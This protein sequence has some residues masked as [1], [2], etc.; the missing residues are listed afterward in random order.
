MNQHCL[1]LTLKIWKVCAAS[2]SPCALSGRKGDCRMNER[3][4]TSSSRSRL[5]TFLGADW[6]S[7]LSHR[8][9]PVQNRALRG[10]WTA[11]LRRPWTPGRTWR[12]LPSHRSASP[13]RGCFS[14]SSSPPLLV[15]CLVC[16]EIIGG[17]LKYSSSSLSFSLVLSV[18]LNTWVRCVH[19]DRA[20]PSVQIQSPSPSLTLASAGTWPHVILGFLLCWNGSPVFSVLGL[21]EVYRSL[22]SRSFLR[23]A[24][25]GV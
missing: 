2:V 9:V 7:C 12:R 1:P 16:L 4:E 6:F 22:F 18:C 5:Q 25:W 11:R 15:L 23:K 21:L 8:L 13:A 3:V 20:R 10:C 24:V 19:P 17:F 14:G